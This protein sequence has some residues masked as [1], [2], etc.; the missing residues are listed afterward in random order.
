VIERGEGWEMHLGDCLDVMPTLDADRYVFVSDPPYGVALR[1][2]MGGAYGD[3]HIANDHNTAIRDAALEIYGDGPA[4]VFGSWKVPRPSE[5][6]TVLTW[7][8]G[9]HVGM[10][11]LAIPWKPNTEEVYVLGSGF[12]G[13][14]TGSVLRHFAIAAGVGTERDRAGLVVRGGRSHPTEKP[15]ALMMELIAKCPADRVVLDPFAGSGST[16]VA[17]LRLGRLFVGIEL[18]P[19][20]FA[21][22]VERL[23]AEEAQT[24]PAQARA[25]QLGLL[26]RLVGGV[27]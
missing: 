2:G 16:G 12:V 4:L 27:K 25:G 9:E 10:G 7:D 11:N 20:H 3:C 24:T 15:L 14:R 26:G 13:A 22:A 19:V 8:K 5:T 1:S 6:H 17:A 21:T 23:R 18:D